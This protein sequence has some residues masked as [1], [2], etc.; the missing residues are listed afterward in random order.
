MN[1]EMDQL[2]SAQ[3][4]VGDT[5]GTR[6]TTTCWQTS[7]GKFHWKERSFDARGDLIEVVEKEV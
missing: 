4:I 3:F 2:L 6:A 7:A 5:Y 1:T